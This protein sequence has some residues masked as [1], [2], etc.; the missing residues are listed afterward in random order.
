MNFEE[1]IGILRPLLNQNTDESMTAVMTIGSPCSVYTGIYY[2]AQVVV[3]P[4]RPD[5]LI[6][7]AARNVSRS[8]FA[9]WRAKIQTLTS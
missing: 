4:A 3:Y 1:S 7:T 5:T 2:I 9:T 8:V 6:E